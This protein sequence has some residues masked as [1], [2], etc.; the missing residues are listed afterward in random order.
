[1]WQRLLVI[2]L[3]LFLIFRFGRMKNNKKPIESDRLLN[4]PW[5]GMAKLIEAQARH[6]TGNYTS[7]LFKR[8]NNVFG[9]RVPNK[10]PFT[11]SGESNGYST[12]KDIDQS[13]EDW[14]LWAE[15]TKFPT[16]LRTVVQYVDALFIRGYFED[17]WMNYSK[18]MISHYNKIGNE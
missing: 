6:E 7:D 11:R 17:N 15:Y 18:S 12:Y 8:A 4:S 1:M 2:A 9:M 10:R 3:V 16:N 5:G 13:I 14:L